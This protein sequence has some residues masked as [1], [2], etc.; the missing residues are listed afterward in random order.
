VISV[1]EPEDTPKTAGVP[2]KVTLLAPV[3]LV[4]RILTTAPTLPEVGCVSTNGPKPTDRLK[5]CQHRWPHHHRLFRRSRRNL[6]ATAGAAEDQR[7]NGTQLAL[8]LMALFSETKT[9]VRCGVVPNSAHRRIPAR[10][11]G[12]YGYK[13]RSRAWDDGVMPNLSLE[14]SCR[15][16]PHY[17]QFGITSSFSTNAFRL[18]LTDS[19]MLVETSSRIGFGFTPTQTTVMA[20]CTSPRSWHDG[21]TL[22]PPLVLRCSSGGPTD[23]AGPGRLAGASGA[24]WVSCDEA[25][26]RDTW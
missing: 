3:R 20:G 24:K 21:N 14:L 26:V 19:T 5:P 8:V 7:R 15:S 2:L 18:Q 12:T 10:I 4:P 13:I 22:I 16:R 11:I 23:R 1:S 6:K 9:V 25:V 17:A